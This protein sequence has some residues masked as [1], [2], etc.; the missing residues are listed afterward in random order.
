VILPGGRLVRAARIFPKAIVHRVGFADTANFRK[1]LAKWAGQ[2]PS[3][4][5]RDIDA[6][7]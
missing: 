5:R 1:A 4:C 6:E 7:R 2:S 3:Q